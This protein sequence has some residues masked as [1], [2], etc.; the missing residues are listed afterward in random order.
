[1]A[2]PIRESVYAPLDKVD[3]AERLVQYLNAH[4]LKMT[5]G[6]LGKIIKHH[7]VG[8]ALILDEINVRE[9]NRGGTRAITGCIVNQHGDPG[10]GYRECATRLG[11]VA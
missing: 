8:L 9:K 1:M 2:T 4:G 10:D 6:D 7:P 11:L 3:T 5:Y